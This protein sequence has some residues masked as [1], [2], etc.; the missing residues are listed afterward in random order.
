MQSSI[1]SILKDLKIHE[2]KISLFVNIYSKTRDVYEEFKIRERVMGMQYNRKVV[3]GLN[4]KL[5]SI[6]S[7]KKIGF[8]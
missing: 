2:A 6:V 3:M 5:M 4:I 8:V 7:S 1:L